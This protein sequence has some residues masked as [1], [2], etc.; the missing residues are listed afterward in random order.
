V[1]NEE[2][3]CFPGCMRVYFDHNATTPVAPA[4]LEAMLP[5]L[6]DEYGNASSI[7]R[8]GQRTRAAVEGARAQVASLIGSKPDEVV[9]TGSGTESDN[10]AILGVVRQAMRRRPASQLHV[11]TSR[12]EHHA[13]L[14]TC[15]AL[16]R[17]GVRVTWLPVS[18]EGIVNPEDVRAAVTADTVL[19]TVMHANNEVGSI[20]PL[21]EISAIARGAGVP[22]HTDAVQSVGKI[23]VD[24]TPL[25]VDLL[26]LSAHKFSGPKGVGALYVRDGVRLA[27]VLFGGS[28][29]SEPR[30]GTE[31]VAGIVGLGAAAELART[32]L[33]QESRHITALRERLERCVL[34]RVEASAVNGPVS[35]A[36]RIPNTSNI[37]FDYIEG[38]SLVIA[39]DL[40][41][42][43][44]STGSACSSGAVE[45][46]HVLLAMG[47]QPQQARSCVR[48]SL[49]SR[50]TE[51]EVDALLATLPNVV[52]R[53][54]AL[55]PL[56]PATATDATP[57]RIGV[58]S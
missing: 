28:R 53:L 6:R 57:S 56:T 3:A 38:E 26:S 49:G 48:F 11:I 16:E 54:R 2:T 22:F 44:C 13:V 31:N 12:I 25:G 39:L 34:E 29:E 21:A 10:L 20:Q 36:K 15:K 40:Q 42:I 50:S 17:D 4:V 14:Y 8:F 7:H 51:G 47:F 24:V 5:Y 45:P 58:T 55:S 52:K 9:F 41:G 27:P 35:D 46:S 37:R 43:A 23:P 1:L 18:H 19:I 32:G 30:P 33:N